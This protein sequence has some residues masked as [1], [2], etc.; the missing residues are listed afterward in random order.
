[1]APEP[2]SAMFCAEG[3]DKNG[4]V[5]A[6]QVRQ[7]VISYIESS[8]TRWFCDFKGDS[9]GSLICK[10]YNQFVA[11]GITSY[12]A[13]CMCPACLASILQY[14]NTRIGSTISQ[15]TY[16]MEFPIYLSLRQ[17]QMIKA[18]LFVQQI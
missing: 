16:N 12:G 1:M 18:L 15:I 8:L 5:D 7:L 4:Q 3:F 17:I 11:I 9:G 14:R 6:C 2:G 13:G 10:R